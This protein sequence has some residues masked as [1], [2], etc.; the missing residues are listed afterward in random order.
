MIRLNVVNHSLKVGTIRVF[1]VSSSSLLQIGDTERVTLYSMLDTPPDSISAYA[2]APL[3]PPE[4]AEKAEGESSE[5]EDSENSDDRNS[6]I[7]IM[8]KDLG[9]E[10]S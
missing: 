8:D 10:R 5:T 6:G 4:G 2:I 7:G 9:A 3:G 1:G